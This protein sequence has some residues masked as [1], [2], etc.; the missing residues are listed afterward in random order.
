[1]GRAP[2]FSDDAILDATCGLVAERG[3]GA[4]TVTAVAAR[5]G[6]PS[7]SIY[8]RFAARDLLVARLWIRTVHRFHPGF[9]DALT[10]DDVDEAARQAMRHTVRW[11]REHPVDARVLLLH[12]REDLVARWPDELGDELADLNGPVVRAVRAYVARRYAAVR[13]DRIAGVRFALLEL[14]YAAVR[15]HLIRGSLPG[16]DEEEFVVVAGMAV[17]RHLDP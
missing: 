4:A 13:T 3:A 9:I 2:K 15:A 7:G 8:H 16:L 5:L 17:L 11:A 12:R 6:A 10:R 14:P 1:M